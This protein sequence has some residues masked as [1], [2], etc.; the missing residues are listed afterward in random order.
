MSCPLLLLEALTLRRQDREKGLR[1]SCVVMITC[2]R[3]SDRKLGLREGS[4]RREWRAAACGGASPCTGP[5]FCPLRRYSRAMSPPE[6]FLGGR[7]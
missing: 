3:D 5:F 6:H 4:Y 1:A 2:S 7:I